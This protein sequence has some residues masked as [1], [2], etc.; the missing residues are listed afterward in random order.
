VYEQA[1]FPL[2]SGVVRHKVKVPPAREASNFKS[3]LLGEIPPVKVTVAAKIDMRPAAGVR[4]VEVVRV[5][6][7]LRPS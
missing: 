4:V 1:A 7:G 2:A 3:K 5:R 6:E